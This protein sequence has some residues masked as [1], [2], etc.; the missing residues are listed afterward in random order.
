M[1]IVNICK[2]RLC[3]LGFYLCYL[4]LSLQHCQLGVIMIPIK[5]VRT[6]W[7]RQLNECTQHPVSIECWSWGLDLRSH[8]ARNRHT[9]Q[10]SVNSRR[11][12]CSPLLLTSPQLHNTCSI[13]VCWMNDWTILWS[14]EIVIWLFVKEEI[15][16]GQWSVLF[17]FGVKCR[18]YIRYSISITAKFLL[19]ISDLRDLEK[20]PDVGGGWK[21]G[22]CFHISQ[23][24]LCDLGKACAFSL[25]NGNHNQPCPVLHF[26]VRVLRF[27]RLPDWAS[28]EGLR[29]GWG[30][31]PSHSGG[32]GVAL[33]N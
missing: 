11:Q 26:P 14:S 13:N 12:A 32:T 2:Q 10:V 18:D 16:A 4:I 15:P 3:I 9:H 25:A 6:F 7:N 20:A 1:I 23:F 24:L 29:A 21:P 28:N 22:F 8:T 33:R 30:V 31:S 5:E 27:L 17:S 19:F